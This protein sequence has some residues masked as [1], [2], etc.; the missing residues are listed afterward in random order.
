MARS[1]RCI[2]GCKYS[3]AKQQPKNMLRTLTKA[4]LTQTVQVIKIDFVNIQ[5]NI[6]KY[7]NRLF[8]PSP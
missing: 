6:S 2:S 1:Q 3:L 7:A 4:A 5:T 8:I